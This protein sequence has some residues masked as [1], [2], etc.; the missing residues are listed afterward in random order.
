[1]GRFLE[2]VFENPQNPLGW[3]FKLFTAWGINVRL[4]LLTLIYLVGLL[5]WSIPASNAGFLFKAPAL[6][7]LFVLVLLH[8]FGHCFACR[9]VGGE[10][11]RI[12]MLPWGGLALVR[13]PQDWRSNLMTTL[14]GPGVNALL[15]PVTVAAL[16]AFGMGDTVVFNPLS[17]ALTLGTISASSEFLLLVKVTLWWTHAINIYLLGFNLLLLMYPFDGGRIC[18]S[19]LWAKIGERRASELATNIGF[20]AGLVLA[21]VGL[22]T[23][24][25]LVLMIALFGI[26]SCWLERR[27]LRGELDVAAEGVSVSGWS[28]A[29]EQSPD[30]RE[31]AAALK[32]AREAEKEQQ[33]LDRLLAKIAE[34][35][36]AS[37][38]RSERKTL[39]RISKKK[40]GE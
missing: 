29:T 22:F 2:R 25:V 31:N 36:I 9:L 21:G 28:A 23:E 14:G 32:A 27:R 3:T 34:N 33:E 15:L 37:L 39:D 16:Y 19:L 13:P 38:S 20:A 10:A 35:G 12:V 17:P 24:S 11:D 30:E 4:H 1:M 18:Q 26:G 8:E 5:V 7:V 6:A 40:R